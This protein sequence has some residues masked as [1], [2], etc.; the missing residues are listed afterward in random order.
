MET[1]IAFINTCAMFLIGAGA[2]IAVWLIA[3]YAVFFVVT[4]VIIA[5]GDS[6][7]DDYRIRTNTAHAGKE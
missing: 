4:L 2:C 1:G 5:L 7:M 3:L 6:W